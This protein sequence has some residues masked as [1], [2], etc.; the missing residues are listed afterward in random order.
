MS[1]MLLVKIAWSEKLL[2][3]ADPRA[4]LEI[5]AGAEC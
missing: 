1:G 4:L 2:L 5:R 3:R